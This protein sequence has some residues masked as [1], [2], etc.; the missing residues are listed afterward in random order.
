MVIE[1]QGA[2]W[3]EDADQRAAATVTS[4]AANYRDFAV[5]HQKGMNH[6][7]GDGTAVQN[8]ASEGQGIPEDSHD[9][10]QKA[11]NYGSEPMW[12]RFGLLPDVPLG[13]GGL[14]DVP[15]P[16]LAYSNAL[17]G[18][19]PATPVFEAAP[20]QAA[21]MRVLEPTGVGRGTTFVLHGHSWQRDPYLAGAVASQT[22]GDNPIGFYL[23]A[24]ESITPGNHF[25]IVLPSAGGPNA[26]PGDYLFRDQAS[27][28]N[29][30]GLWGIM[31]VE[32]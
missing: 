3:T 14:G 32:P 2:T 15:N 19:D 20:G 13:K 22:I 5:V 10:G 17:A 9:A 26:V 11:I 25:D 24:Q 31:R 21:R 1:P 18:G 7:F 29:T 4:A 16:E 6:R 12:F 30:D 28:G 27:F 8:I 23:S